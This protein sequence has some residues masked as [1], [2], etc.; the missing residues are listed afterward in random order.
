MFWVIL[1]ITAILLCFGYV[2]LFG[3]PYLPTLN[4]Q[5]ETTIKLA[6]LSPGQTVIELGCGDGRVMAAFAKKGV[7]SIGYELNP[8]MFVICWLRLRRYGDLA[9]VRFG[10]FWQKTWP[11]ADVIYTFLL[12]K[13]M[14]RL[15][16][17]LESYEHK[18][19]TLISY[20]FKIS[21]RRPDK[22]KNGLFV[23]IYR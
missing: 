18:P 4:L 22:S 19:V 23:Y 10:N 11:P 12:S 1:I 20:A 2:L 16:Q 14:T 3:A 9:Q 8:I 15:D 7:K 13:Y 21:G 5:V 17:S 6:N